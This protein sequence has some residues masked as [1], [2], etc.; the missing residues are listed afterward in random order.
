MDKE[1]LENLAQIHKLHHEAADANE[2]QGLIQSGSVRLKPASI[3]ME[4]S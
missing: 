3:Q 4:G 1:A 2:I